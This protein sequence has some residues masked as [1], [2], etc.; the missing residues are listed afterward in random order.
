MKICIISTLPPLHSG[1]SEYTLGLIRGL[2]ESNLESVVFFLVNKTAKISFDNS[3]IKIVKVW[4]KGPV[5]F[6]QLLRAIIS[7]NP[8]VVHF[9]HEFFL[10]G[11]VATALLFPILLMITHFIGI[12][13][14]VTIH[15][16]ISNKLNIS[17]FANLFLV[18]NY[19][20]MIKIGLRIITLFIC[21]MANIIIVHNDFLKDILIYEYNIPNKKIKVIRHGIGFININE[22]NKSKENV[23]LFFGTISPNKG[24]EVL[25]EAFEKVKMPEIEL[26]IAGS[27]HPRGSE[28]L[29]SIQLRIKASSASSRIS[30]TGYVKNENIY[31]LFENATVVVFPYLL[32]VSSSGGLSFALQHKKPVIVTSLP[33]FM[34]IIVHEETGIIVPPGNVIA[35]SIAIEKLLK[36]KQLQL[37]MSKNITK[38]YENMTWPVIAQKTILAYSS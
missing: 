22:T 10:Y 30:L 27:S 37:E 14:V 6:F 38:K 18:S 36:N 11:G 2:E 24:L 34:E 8:D 3:K 12:K 13:N 19:Y 23:V 21:T 1:V 33:S 26:V 4:E 29:N 25:I 5:F 20:I 28:Y 16:V 7:I 15:G 17:N 35:L 9:Q 31:S 32:S